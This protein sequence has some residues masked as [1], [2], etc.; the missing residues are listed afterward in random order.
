MLDVEIS[1]LVANEEND[2]RK[3][4]TPKKELKVIAGSHGLT[5]KKKPT[6][7]PILLTPKIT[8]HPLLP[9]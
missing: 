9:R 4:L 8:R 3:E 1:E 7:N 6:L 5:Q 2:L